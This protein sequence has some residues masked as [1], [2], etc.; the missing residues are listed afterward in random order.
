MT[1]AGCESEKLPDALKAATLWATGVRFARGR[2]APG[3]L[4]ISGRAGCL[5]PSS[6]LLSPVAVAPGRKLIQDRT[7]TLVLVR[8][9]SE[10]VSCPPTLYSQRFDSVIFLFS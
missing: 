2:W 6:H 3:F 9:V 8:R 7:C 1:S 10:V 4:G 5:Q